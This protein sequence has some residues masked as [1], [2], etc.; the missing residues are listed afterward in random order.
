LYRQK[1]AQSLLLEKTDETSQEMALLGG[2]K[3]RFGEIAPQDCWK[4]VLKKSQKLTILPMCNKSVTSLYIIC[5]KLAT[6][7]REARKLTKSLKY[8]K[9]QVTI[10]VSFGSRICRMDFYQKYI[11]LSNPY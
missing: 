5:N 11:I 4:I 9:L 1:I 3:G 2:E 10:N 6:N 8:D 7:L